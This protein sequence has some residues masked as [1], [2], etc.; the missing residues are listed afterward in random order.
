MKIKDQ[1][2]LWIREWHKEYQQRR[3]WLNG[4]QNL[5]EKPRVSGPDLGKELP[6][7][8]RKKAQAETGLKPG[9]KAP[10]AK[11]TPAFMNSMN[12]EGETANEKPIC[13]GEGSEKWG[14]P[15]TSSISDSLLLPLHQS[16]RISTYDRYMEP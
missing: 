2:S 8:W 16:P 11:L 3:K 13:S 7:Q 4:C 5:T 12:V 6:I 10:H 15:V 1:Q 14:R 9:N